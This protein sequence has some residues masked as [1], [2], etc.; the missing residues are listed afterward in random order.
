MNEL[1]IYTTI[2]LLA[3]AITF[4]RAMAG[5]MIPKRF[6]EI[7]PVTEGSVNIRLLEILFTSIKLK[8]FP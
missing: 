7:S 6:T 1:L 2:G 5:S 8:V 4:P 3:I